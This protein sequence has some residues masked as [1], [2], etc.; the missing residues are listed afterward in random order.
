M[1]NEGDLRDA[2][3]IQEDLGETLENLLDLIQEKAEY[4]TIH[5]GVSMSQA[6]ENNLYS[7]SDTIFHVFADAVEGVPTKQAKEDLAEDFLLGMKKIHEKHGQSVEDE[8]AEE[9][10]EMLQ[11]AISQM[12]GADVE[13]ESMGVIEAENREEAMEKLKDQLE[14]R[15]KDSKGK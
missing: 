2:E 5:E 9:V 15:E 6:L 3:E 1:T 13:V 11:E 10:G 14:E 12:T 8:A 4:D 7:V